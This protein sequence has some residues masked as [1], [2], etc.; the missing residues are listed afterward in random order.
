MQFW[1]RTGLHS[2]LSR[3]NLG[4][5]AGVDTIAA[6]AAQLPRNGAGRAPKG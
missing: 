4:A 1:D 3:T 2:A 5:L 6:I